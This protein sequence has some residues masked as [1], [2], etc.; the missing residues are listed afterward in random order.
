MMLEEPEQQL[1]PLVRDPYWEH[2]TDFV[3][4]VKNKTV[5]VSTLRD[6][7]RS[8]NISQLCD[9]AV[10]TQSTVKWDPIKMQLI[11]PTAAQTALLD[12]PMRAPWSL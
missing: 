9:I 1:P 3:A 4:G 5:P 2:I 12:R 10:R 7:V 8:D 6:A 11:D